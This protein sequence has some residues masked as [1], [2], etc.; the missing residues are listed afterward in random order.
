MVSARAMVRNGFGHPLGASP[1]FRRAR[2]R[3]PLDARLWT[4]ARVGEPAAP[5]R[6]PAS[7][8]RATQPPTMR[9][10]SRNV[11]RQY[12]GVWRL[13]PAPA[14][15]VGGRR[16]CRCGPAGQRGSRPHWAAPSR[17]FLP[18][19][20]NSASPRLAHIS[21]GI[22]APEALAPQPMRAG[23]LPAADAPVAPCRCSVFAGRGADL[24]WCGSGGVQPRRHAA[25]HRWQ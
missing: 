24:G 4:T 8:L 18:G 1:G 5:S 17:H 15:G 22:C 25:G 9:A 16:S 6:S 20:R 3:Y 21:G 7:L 11:I 13:A 14:V 19:A 2:V 23:R 10:R 12:D